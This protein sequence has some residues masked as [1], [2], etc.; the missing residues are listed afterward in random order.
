MIVLYRLFTNKYISIG[1]CFIK[2][3]CINNS[4]EEVWVPVKYISKEGVVV[5]FTGI[6]EVSNMNK[7]KTLPKT[8]K[9]GHKR[10]EK[11]LDFNQSP[12][13]GGYVRI[14]LY[15]GGA[16]YNTSFHRIVMSSFCPISET[17]DCID[18][19]DGN[20]ANSNLSNLRWCNSSQNKLNPSTN[21]PF[22]EEHRRNISLGRTGMHLSEEHK[23]HI[24][25]G[26]ARRSSH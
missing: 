4:M 16:K 2:L 22:T 21:K 14:S 6:Y 24:S 10:N 8:D 23:R 25:E 11:I 7:F 13:K 17:Y 20:P 19:I 26:L 3:F 9:R 12:R 1:L 15:K 5:D 18:H